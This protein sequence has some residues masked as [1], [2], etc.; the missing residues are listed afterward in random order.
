MFHVCTL[1]HMPQGICYTGHYSKT[2]YSSHIFRWC[3]CV[4]T[5]Q[6]LY[7]T[8]AHGMPTS[9]GISE[10]IHAFPLQ[11]THIHCVPCMHTKYTRT[12]TF[13][14]HSAATCLHALETWLVLELPAPLE[15]SCGT[16]NH[17]AACSSRSSC[18]SFTLNQIVHL[19][20]VIGCDLWLLNSSLH[21]TERESSYHWRCSKYPCRAT[22]LV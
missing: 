6:N 8:C 17:S 10:F 2:C 1:K 11:G 22:G 21:S 13:M 20:L 4:L 18:K 12:N 15:C 5:Q 3:T 7:I 14:Q 9:C 19:S 16:A